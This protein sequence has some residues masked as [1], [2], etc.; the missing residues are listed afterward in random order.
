[1]EGYGAKVPIYGDVQIGDHLWGIPKVTIYGAMRGPLNLIGDH[2]WGMT[3][4]F[5][6]KKLLLIG[7]VERSIKF[8]STLLIGDHLWGN[9]KVTIYGEL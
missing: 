1:V 5:R 6:V 8:F 3:G 7:L 2:L 4:C 9:L